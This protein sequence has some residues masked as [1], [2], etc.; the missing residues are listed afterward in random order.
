MAAKATQGLLK[1]V[2]SCHWHVQLYPAHV[3]N[4]YYVRSNTQVSRHAPRMHSPPA[5]LVHSRNK[6]LLQIF[7]GMI[8]HSE[9][10]QLA[11]GSPGLD[12]ALN[13]R[14]PTSEQIWCRAQKR[15]A[16]GFYMLPR[17]L[18]SV[19]QTHAPNIA[20]PGCNHVRMEQH[21]PAPPWEQSHRHVEASSPPKQ[22]AST[23]H[24][25]CMILPVYL[26]QPGRS[27]RSHT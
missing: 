3:I 25:C 26:V 14:F 10:S 15:H 19:F 21:E 23:Q 17:N 16:C 2:S 20:S 18:R 24:P 12:Q 7:G 4:H 1:S 13:L 6:M 9:R 8:Q 5:L 27:H 22:N 11:A